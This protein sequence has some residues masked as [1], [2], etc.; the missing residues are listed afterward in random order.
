MMA[1]LK[2]FNNEI[3]FNGNS[4]QTL[5]IENKNLFRQVTYAFENDAT[6]EYFVFSRN[7]E[8]F[9]F[10]KKGIY[11][12]NVINVDLNNK[13][14]ISKINSQLEKIANDEYY[15][16]FI[17]VRGK[18][19]ELAD[20]LVEKE[21]FNIE[22]NYDIDLKS[23]IKLFDFKLTIKN[24]D[25][26][27]SFINYIKLVSQCLG[28]LLFVVSNLHLFF[29]ANELD[30]IYETLSLCEIKMICIESLKT[31]NISKFEV[32]HIIDNDLCEIE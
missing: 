30:L 9:D 13:K 24:E 10:N 11:I 28:V 6:D 8:P 29:D 31:D 12:D 14:I 1:V 19:I 18:L 27:E 25:F 21:D 23:L 15:N 5:I 20:K 17:E 3:K 26:A 7:Y 2:G 4:F 32:I 22:Y 16:D